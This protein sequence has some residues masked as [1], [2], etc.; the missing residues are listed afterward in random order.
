MLTKVGNGNCKPS[1]AFLPV[2]FVKRSPSSM[3]IETAS[4]DIVD[5]G[6]DAALPNDRR[7][8]HNPT[9]P[10]RRLEG[11]PPAVLSKGGRQQY[12]SQR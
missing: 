4:I 1:P 10:R 7:R 12:C 11:R 9:S 5:R 8:C 2:S 3:L 6:A